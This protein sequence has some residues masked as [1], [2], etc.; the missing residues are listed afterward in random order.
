MAETIKTEKNAVVNIDE[1]KLTELR[2][3]IA[4]YPG[5]FRK[6]TFSYFEC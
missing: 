2:K 6:E 4:D 1:K 5:F 3:L